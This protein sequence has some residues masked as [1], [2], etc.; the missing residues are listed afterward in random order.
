[1]VYSVWK[2][3]LF[4]FILIS[5]SVS[6][7]GQGVILF[8]NYIDIEELGNPF[9]HPEWGL[10][11]LNP[12]TPNAPPVQFAQGMMSSPVLSP[13]GSTLVFAAPHIKIQKAIG[14]YSVPVS[15]G[16]PTVISHM[17]GEAGNPSFSPDGSMVV[18][19]V[20]LPGSGGGQPTPT[21][22]QGLPLQPGPGNSLLK[23][24]QGDFIF[25]AANPFIAI[26]RMDGSDA[27]GVYHKALPHQGIQQAW[28]RPSWHPTDMNRIAVSIRNANQV[29]QEHPSIP[30]L[31][32]AGIYVVSPDASNIRLL[33][34]PMQPD[35][36][37]GIFAWEE[38]TAP[39]WSPDGQRIAYV[40]QFIELNRPTIYSIYIMRADGSDAPGVPVTPQFN[41]LAD[42]GGI[43][44]ITW[45]PDGQWLAFSVSTEIQSGVPAGYDLFMVKTD[46]SNLTQITR[47]AES[48]RPFWISGDTLPANFSQPSQDQLTPTPVPPGP[49]PSATPSTGGSGYDLKVDQVFIVQDDGGGSFDDDVEITNPTVGQSIRFV[50][51]ISNPGSQPVPN[52][53]VDLYV[54]GELYNS[55]TAETGL[56]AGDWDRWR[57]SPWT[58]NAPGTYT[59]EWRF[60]VPGDSNPSDNSMTGT[61]TVLAE[62]GPTPTI[63]QPTA[64][65]VPLP[66]STPLPPPTATPPPTGGG[67]NLSLENLYIVQDD[68][69]GSLDDDVE[70][71]EIF[72]GQGIRFYA[73]VRNTGDQPI[74]SYTAELYINGELYNS[75]TAEN[76][77]AAGQ[78]Q[79]WRSTP[80]TADRG[81]FH[82]FEWRFIVPGD[83]NPNDNTQS[84]TFPVATGGGPFPTATPTIPP[85]P[86]PP[87]GTG[88]S[89]V[90]E[91]NGSSLAEMGWSELPGGFTGKPAGS[92]TVADFAVGLFP[93][94]QDHRGLEI[95][96]DPGAVGFIYLTQPV[97]SNVPVLMRLTVRTDRQD[98]SVAIAAL[99][100]NLG[101][102]A[103]DGSIASMIPANSSSYTNQP[104]TL[105]LVYKPDGSNMISPVIQVASNSASDQIE[106][107]I[108]RLEIIPL[109]P[110]QNYSGSLF[111]N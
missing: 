62:G 100:G 31:F 92:V 8:N 1:M 49:T 95:R 80:W 110:A 70:I 40:R 26:A 18:Y 71:S 55:G 68:G 17:I 108:D 37:N 53:T 2:P 111:G 23:P 103:S 57:S 20:F 87:P 30:P 97:Q 29:M 35:I 74:P 59:F 6:S 78:T 24:Q 79:R 91:F 69:G 65:P 60:T 19:E 54:N 48:N 32:G 105:M 90:Y 51:Y 85:N 72:V 43:N 76:P 89:L 7:W 93:N 58:A 104:G 14:L 64:T 11:Y 4:I 56:P 67:Y 102:G 41:N 46:G 109:D 96:V 107:S 10:Y 33:F 75:S 73:L 39:A 22:T 47:N 13:D 106:V 34:T 94:S 15:G 12:F 82:T 63:S 66:T 5:L 84:V 9:Q 44:Q 21:P 101:A 16:I 52:Y 45:S 88:D 27:E 83:A 61:I 36:I 50:T 28:S 25:P 77:L 3:V 42:V 86:T 81:G 98:A 38:D 99:K